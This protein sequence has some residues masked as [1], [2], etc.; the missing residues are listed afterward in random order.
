VGAAALDL[1]WLAAGRVDAYYERGLNP[2]DHAAGALVAREAGAVVGGPPSS[3]DDPSSEL[4]WA[5]GPDLAGDFHDLI[6]G[7]G[8]DR[9]L[10]G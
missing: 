9:D 10:A 7:A 5:A 4:T 6:L 3:P 2:W 8:A 1:C